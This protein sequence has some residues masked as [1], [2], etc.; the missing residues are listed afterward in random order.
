MVEGSLHVV[1]C[2]CDISLSLA[3][4]DTYFL[5]RT[6]EGKECIGKGVVGFPS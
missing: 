6:K 3:G 5:S 2:Q 4:I 1:W